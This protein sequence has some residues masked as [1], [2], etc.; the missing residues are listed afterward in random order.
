M[1]DKLESISDICE[2]VYKGRKF[3]MVEYDILSFSQN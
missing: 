3:T 1:M 2:F